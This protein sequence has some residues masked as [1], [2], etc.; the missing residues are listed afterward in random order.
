VLVSWKAE[1]EVLG[2]VSAELQD[3]Q[4]RCSATSVQLSACQ[5]GH[6]QTSMKHV[7]TMY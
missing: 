4:K 5:V 7:I 6:L 2:E 3:K 1:L